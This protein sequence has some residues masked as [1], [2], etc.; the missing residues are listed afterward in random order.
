MSDL[1]SKEKTRYDIAILI[2]N[3]NSLIDRWLAN[4]IDDTIDEQPTIEAEPKHGRWIK[5][6]SSIFHMELPACSEC[7]RF[8]ALEWHYCPNCGAQMS[9][10]KNE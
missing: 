9:E 3:N 2:M 10:V 6:W 1:I 5:K 4:C 8:S 7:G